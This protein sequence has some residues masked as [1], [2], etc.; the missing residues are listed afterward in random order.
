M[1]KIIS[2]IL[3]IWS[4]SSLQ[5]KIPLSAAIKKGIQI[6][7]KIQNQLLEEKIKYSEKKIARGKR[8]FS[9]NLG[10]SY[11]YK[12][13]QIEIEFPPTDL[14]DGIT[15]PGQKII[16]GAQHNIDFNLSLIQPFYLGGILRNQVKLKNTEINVSQ[17]LTEI[18]IL[19]VASR[20][21]ASYFNY[22]LLSNKKKALQTLIKKISLHRQKLFDFYNEELIKKSDL[23]E[24]DSKI[25]EQ[26]LLL[27]DLENLIKQETITFNTLCGLE[28]NSISETYSEQEVS[29]TEGL[30]LF[31]KDH[32]LLQSL[33]QKIA[34]LKLQKKII[35]GKYLPQINGFAELHYAKPGI[36]FFQNLWSFYFQGG[37]TI[38]LKLFD[39][40]QKKKENDIFQYN[41]EKLNNIKNDY[42]RNGEKILKQL[43]LK[44]Q[45]A[46][47]K[48]KTL[49][50]LIQISTE[51]IQLK[52]E[53]LEQQQIS[54]IDYLAALT[55]REQYVAKRDEIAAQIEFI[56][57]NINKTIGLPMG[58]KKGEQK[59]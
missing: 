59:K 39:W 11:L 31:K 21:K 57:V 18:K 45:S 25:Q 2:L 19:E 49:S 28:I 17:L 4:W 38:N 10:G 40:N 22:H 48:L 41:F 29:L 8:L 56:K 34:G 55:T 58:Y 53:L 14:G 20:I 47:V 26:Y 15:L 7:F 42:I 36:D 6:N 35:S 37:I 16:A 3:L 33:N 23:L 1:K 32:P 52:E 12:S 50:Q 5:A 9:L 44:K 54:N 43:Y 13:Q 30:I 46:Q 24:T 27:E 51:D